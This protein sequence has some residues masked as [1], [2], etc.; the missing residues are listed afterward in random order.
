MARFIIRPVAAQGD[1]AV[2]DTQRRQIVGV[3]PFADP[4]QAV[5]RCK[6]ECAADRMTACENLDAIDR[7]LDDANEED[8]IQRAI[9]DE[10]EDLWRAHFEG[11]V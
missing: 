2:I 10:I 4:A 7:V 6:A 8:V 11:H 3:V 1:L 9:D 5:A